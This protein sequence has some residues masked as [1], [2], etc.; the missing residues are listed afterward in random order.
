[1]LDLEKALQGLQQSAEH[2]G[3]QEDESGYM[4]SMLLISKLLQEE[5]EMARKN[6]EL[7]R[8]REQQHGGKLVPLTL[9]CFV[10]NQ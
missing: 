10:D 4:K 1:V 8:N 7:E 5:D 6:L 9:A 3:A 2:T